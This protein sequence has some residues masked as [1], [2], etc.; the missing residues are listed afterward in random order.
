MAAMQL[1]AALGHVNTP[2]SR[3]LSTRRQPAAT[4]RPD[5]RGRGVTVCEASGKRVL[6]LGGTGRVG[7][8]TAAALLQLESK[9]DVLLGGRKQSSY[10]QCLERRPELKGSAFCQCDIT[11][12]ASLTAALGGVD[13]VVHAAGPFQRKEDLMVLETCLEAKTPYMDICD[14]S[15]YSKMVKA[16]HEAAVAAGVPA[17]TT[18]GIYPGVSNVMA[19]HMISTA[20][21]EYDDDGNYVG[22]SGEAAL[23]NPTRVL[24]SYFTAGSG[25]AGPTI[26]ETSFLLAGE[27]VT[28][29]KDGK[30]VTVPPITER[31]VVDFG[32]GIGR[33]GVYLYNLPEIFSTHT[34]LGVPSVS[35]RFGTSEIWNWA[36]VAV[37]RLVPK[38]VLENRE[39]VGKLAALSDPLV[40]AVDSIVG[41]KVSMKIEIDFTDGTN[42]CGLFT[43]K[44]LSE[45]VGYSTAA[46]ANAMLNGETEPGVWF[47]EEP[48]A[49]KNRLALLE[50]ASRGCFAFGL[51]KQFWQIEG[52]PI[53]LG[54]G[55]YL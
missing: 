47:P 31:R 25:G 18:A 46:F 39:A 8:S 35:A 36:M 22:S 20:R 27:D 50:L 45:S 3:Q 21:K 17:I 7:S 2:K 54:M 41:E 26:L 34:Y 6:V 49:V 43:H 33:K 5:R 38:N 9:P 19:A 14:D 10:A 28:A 15:D 48:Q 4:R 44:Y 53:Q 12:Q 29:F 37:A 1:T 23:V 16:K 40:R 30:A 42:T 13:L 32:P 24:Y 55:M 11:D 52:D 51:N